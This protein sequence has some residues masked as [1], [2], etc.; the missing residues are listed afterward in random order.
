M[1]YTIIGAIFSFTLAHQVSSAKEL[2]KP[3]FSFRGWETQIDGLWCEPRGGS[4]FWYK[5]DFYLNYLDE[6]LKRAPYY[7][8]NALILMGRG[9]H[10]EV[11]TVISYRNWPRL[12]EIYK[13]RGRA[14]RELQIKKLNELVTKA[15]P[16]GME[17]YIW[18]HELHLP[19]E[20]ATEYPS[21]AG[22]RAPFCPSEP[23]L[24]RFVSGK[25]EEFFD[26]VP[27][28]AGMFL[29]LSETQF[30]LLPGS[31]CQCERC[32]AAPP[33]QFLE[34]VIR[35]VAQPLAQRGKRLV[36]RTFGESADQC[37]QI[38]TAVNRLPADLEFTVM[39]KSTTQ[40]F[41]G[42][43]YPDH[44]AFKL[45]KARPQFLEDVFGEFRG[46]TNVIVTPADFYRARIQRAATAGVQGVVLRLDHNG[47]PKS[48]FETANEF[49]IY[50]TSRL[51]TNPDSDPDEVWNE[52]V[53]RRYGSTSTIFHYPG[54]QRLH[55][56]SRLHG[57]ERLELAWVPRA[58]H[59]HIE[60]KR[61]YRDYVWQAALRT[62]DEVA[63]TRRGLPQTTG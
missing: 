24:W 54:S 35:A 28:L 12:H 8:A 6:V 63:N 60:N 43:R 41:V 18:T 36:V 42:L 4:S 27:G 17:V 11:P 61:S 52:W 5:N 44:P 48:N 22:I 20:L 46:K 7:D 58:A 34:S 23:D 10:G 32:Q 51:W 59:A 26:R 1:K 49:N 15:K 57:S 47:Y 39:S 40:D 14:D 55:S 13:D 21:T 53:Q 37:R 3:F 29:V 33:E 30:N 31:P 9:N 19:P 56:E 25:Y 38:C 16:H 2:E 45:I 50:F 62:V